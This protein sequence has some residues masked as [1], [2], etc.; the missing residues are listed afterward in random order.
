MK[1]IIGVLVVGA[2][3]LVGCG[4]DD[5][6]DS[7][8]ANTTAKEKTT[9]TEAP[10]TTTAA[11]EPTA[12][13]VFTFFND[14]PFF[15]FA[16]EIKNPADQARVGMRTTWKVLDSNGVIVGTLE[17]TERPAIPAG[18]SIWYVGG[19]GA[20]NL[21]GTPAS[22]EFEITDPGT[23]TDSVPPSSVVA[24]NPTFERSTFD[25][26]DGARSYDA[27]F[28]IAATADVTTDDIGTV[29]LLRDAAGNIVAADWADTNAVP[30]TL[31]AGEKANATATLQVANGE[32]ATVGAYVYD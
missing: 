7:G 1:R 22:V 23:L 19:A 15:R 18:G 9:T 20:A 17:D 11:A 21:T 10:T 13:V 2:F 25:F 29:V 26:Y 32:P 8:S 12:E 31:K 6:S 30:S 5:T 27:S 28:V 3:L 24:E 14:D 16:V 4:S